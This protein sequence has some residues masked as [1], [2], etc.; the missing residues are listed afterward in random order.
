MRLTS[1]ADLDRLD[2]RKG[3]GLLPLIAQEAPAGEVLMLGF[4]DR[5]ALARSLRDGELWFFSRTRG[6]LWRKGETSGHTLRVLS[7]HADCDGDAVLARVEPRGPTCHTGARSCFSAP[8]LLVELADVVAARAA[9]A[10]AA[11][12]DAPAPASPSYTRRLLADPNLRLKKLGEESTEL[13][14]ACAAGDSARVAEEAAD[15]LYHLL[16]AASAAGAPLGE[17]LAALGRRR[18]PAER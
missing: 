5:D 9:E 17:V 10:A 13:A 12:P 3:G 7:L 1:E 15:L 4:A 16:V 6:R 14:L 11:T 2:F 8:P 18:S